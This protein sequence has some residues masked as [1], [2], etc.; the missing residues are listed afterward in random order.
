MSNYRTNCIRIR[1]SDYCISTAYALR[2]SNSIGILITTGGEVPLKEYEADLK[3]AKE[4][5]NISVKP[6]GL[7]VPKIEV[8]RLNQ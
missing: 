1:P 4:L 5:V 7:P 3:T 8:I 6:Y 2:G